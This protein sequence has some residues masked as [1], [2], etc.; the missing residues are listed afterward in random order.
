VYV[1]QDFLAQ[2]LVFNM[3]QDLITSAERR[4]VRKSR[5]KQYRYAIRI[6]E[7]IAIGLFKNQF[8]NLIM[9]EDD[10]R[11]DKKFRQLTDDMERYIVP[12]R[13]NQPSAPRKWNKRNKYKC[14]LKPS[15]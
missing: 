6:N 10:H 1:E 12:V 8:I 14:N 7:N 15:F 2:V 9:E 4:A 5:K 3:V 11:K 13:N